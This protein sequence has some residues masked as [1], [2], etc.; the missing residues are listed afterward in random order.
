MIRRKIDA[1]N[2]VPEEPATEE[3]GICRILVRLPKGLK[4]ERRFLRDVHTLKV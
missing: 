3:R 2:F 1:V 4:L